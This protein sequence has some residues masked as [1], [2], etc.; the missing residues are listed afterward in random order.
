MDLAANGATTEKA[1]RTVPPSVSHGSGRACRTVLASSRR[2]GRRSAIKPLGPT[3]AIA[4][5]SSTGG[6]TASDTFAPGAAD[7]R[8][9]SGRT[10]PPLTAEERLSSRPLSG[11][12]PERLAPARACSCA[13]RWT[14]ETPT[15]AGLL[16]GLTYAII[17]GG[18]EEAVAEAALLL[19][20][21]IE[22]RSILSPVVVAK[23]LTC[24]EARQGASYFARLERPSARPASTPRNG[25]ST[26]RACSTP[27]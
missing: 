15:A 26:P 20:Q 13:G 1:S 9:G 27:A 10:G 2:D 17:A 3:L 19:D 18:G 6:V 16:L 5:V 7:A 11:L 12:P 24:R 4:T 23:Y 21:Q 8:G 14:R 22:V 25:C